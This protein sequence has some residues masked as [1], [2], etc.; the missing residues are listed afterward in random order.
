MGVKGHK[1]AQGSF[2]GNGMFIISIVVM[3][4]CVNMS[5][6]C[7]WYTLSV[8]IILSY[9]NYTSIK[10]KIHKQANKTFC[11]RASGWLNQ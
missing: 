6:F 10:Q 1:G 3:V 11:H 2:W 9:V 5:K 7:K 8:S 4:S